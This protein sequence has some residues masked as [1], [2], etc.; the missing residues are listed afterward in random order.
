MRVQWLEGTWIAV[1]GDVELGEPRS[2][3]EMPPSHA[4]LSL[5]EPYG[6][7]P[8]G[9]YRLDIAQQ[10]WRISSVEAPQKEIGSWATAKLPPSL[11]LV[12]AATSSTSPPVTTTRVLA[13]PEGIETVGERV[14]HA[15]VAQRGRGERWQLPTE[16]LLSGLGFEIAETVQGEWTAAAFDSVSL[17]EV[18]DQLA[19]IS[20][21]VDAV[22]APPLVLG[23]W[24]DV[25]SAQTALEGLVGAIEALP[26]PRSEQVRRWIVAARALSC[27]GSEGTLRIEIAGSPPRLEAEYRGPAAD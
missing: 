27:L 13:L 1:Q 11:A 25:A 10:G 19:N 24:L 9:L 26:I 23:L 17:R 6:P 14:T 7:V 20:A 21:L 8:E 22:E 5:E 18:T 15:V 3:S 12:A 16:R 2:V 4:L